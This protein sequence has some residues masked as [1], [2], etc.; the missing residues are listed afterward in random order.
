MQQV[1]LRFTIIFNGK[2][3]VRA[4]YGNKISDQ[5]PGVSRWKARIYMGNIKESA[6]LRIL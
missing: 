2:T 1:S 4:S 5:T 6:S 3:D